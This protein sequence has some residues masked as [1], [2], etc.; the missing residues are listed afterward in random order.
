ML[1]CATKEWKKEKKMRRENL[2][3]HASEPIYL[4]LDEKVNT[5]LIEFSGGDAPNPKKSHI[6]PANHTIASAFANV[7]GKCPTCVAVACVRETMR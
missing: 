5:S 4:Q 3:E 2:R 1:N 6:I 7:N